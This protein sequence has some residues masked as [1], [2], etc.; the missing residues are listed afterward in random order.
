MLIHPADADRH[1]IAD[2]MTVAVSSPRGTVVLHA[3]L[4]A[5]L[6]RGVV[7]AESV[8][9]NSAYADG[10]GI[11]T[12][13]AATAAAPLG[14]AVFHDNKVALRPLTED[15]FTPGPAGPAAEEASTHRR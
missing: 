5:G 4:F 10:R 13:T 11:N 14:G 2:G 12:L 7:I 9:P 6:R 3:R 8:W 15:S 1:G